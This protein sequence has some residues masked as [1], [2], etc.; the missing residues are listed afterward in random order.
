MPV[1]VKSNLTSRACPEAIGSNCVE[2]SGGQLCSAN[3]CKGNITLT[4]VITAM[5]NAIC[6]TNSSVSCYTGNWVDFSG[7]IPLSGS[8]LG[9]SYIISGFGFGGIGNPSYKWTKDGDLSLRGG[10]NI[11]IVVTVPKL[12]IDVPMITIPVTCPPSSWVATQNIL[13][14]VDMFP[15]P[16]VQMAFNA[17]LDYPTGRLHGLYQYSNIAMVPM[18]INIDLGG[19]RFN[20]A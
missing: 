13:C 4:D 10:F 11:D 5:D 9:Y 6:G 2:W 18:G 20:L 19:S 8:G 12:Y 1:P 3:L 15:E 16:P 17:T 7:S 14:G